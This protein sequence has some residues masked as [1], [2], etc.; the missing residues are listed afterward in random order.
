MTT[1]VLVGSIG[2]EPQLKEINGKRYWQISV[3]HHNGK[4]DTVWCRVLIADY[5]Q[6]VTR[7]ASGKITVIG[8]P[9]ISCYEGKAQITIWCDKYEI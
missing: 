2:C 8:R 9:V 5:G 3:A 1:I 6:D 7:L 4:D